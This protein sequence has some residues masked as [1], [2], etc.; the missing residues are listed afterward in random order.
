MWFFKLIGGLMFFA[1]FLSL[2]G[3]LFGIGYL[4]WATATGVAPAAAGPA[5][6]VG[7]GFGWGFGGFFHLLG[8]IFLIAIFIG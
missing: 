3:G 2:L 5:Y 1:L 8:T 7:W 4:A 6:G